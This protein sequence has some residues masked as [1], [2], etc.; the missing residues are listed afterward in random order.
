LI[1]LL[2]KD[3]PNPAK[4]RG[5]RWNKFIMKTIKSENTKKVKGPAVFYAFTL[6]AAVFGFRKISP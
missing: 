6:T 2:S 1:V 5:G 4:A 3:T